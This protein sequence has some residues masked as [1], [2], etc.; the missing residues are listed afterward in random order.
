MGFGA[1][2]STTLI[3]KGAVLTGDISFNGDLEI[4]G[5]VK[6]NITVAGKGNAVVRI[7]EGGRVEGEIRAP[8]VMVNGELKG[9]IHASEHIELAAKAMVE[10]NVHYSFI[11]M[12]KGAQ[13][14]GSLLYAGGKSSV[15][16]ESPSEQKVD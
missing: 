3:A 2:H 6:G 10:G 8:K 16:K 13:V 15:V 11:E 9:D 12:V 5:L 1:S 4:Q 14:N 7:V